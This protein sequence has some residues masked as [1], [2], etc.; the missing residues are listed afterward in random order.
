MTRELRTDP[1]VECGIGKTRNSHL[2]VADHPLAE[3]HFRGRWVFAVQNLPRRGPLC[4]Q[5]NRETIVADGKIVLTGQ[6]QACRPTRCDHRRRI[7][8]KSGKSR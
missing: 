2:R 3:W 8:A 4:L 5:L 1:A 6:L 7:G